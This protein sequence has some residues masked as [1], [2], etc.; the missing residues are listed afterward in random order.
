M[1]WSYDTETHHVMVFSGLQEGYQAG[2][3]DCRIGDRMVPLIEFDEALKQT[4]KREGIYYNGN[5]WTR[6]LILAAIHVA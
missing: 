6:A 2:L 4:R 3:L 1:V 5:P